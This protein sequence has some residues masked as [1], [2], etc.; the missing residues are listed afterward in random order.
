MADL[1]KSVGEGLDTGAG[2]TWN[3]ANNADQ[4][5][6]FDS[7]DII[8]MR[9][10]GVT[11]R[12]I[13]VYSA[14]EKTTG[15]INNITDTLTSGVTKRFGPFPANGWRQSNGKLKVKGAHAE[16]LIAIL[17]AGKGHVIVP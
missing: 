17:P 16:V 13:T 14:P 4:E 7:G 5:I 15:R 2:V 1:V 6:A 8:L 11:G 12:A 3:A 9:N 10:S